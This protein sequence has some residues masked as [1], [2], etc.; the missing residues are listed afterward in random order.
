MPKRINRWCCVCGTKCSTNYSKR[1]SIEG[2]VCNDIGCI[3]LD[4]DL[5]IAKGCIEWWHDNAKR[6]DVAAAILDSELLS[7]ESQC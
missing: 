2:Y 3:N 1:N 5:N 4:V 7:K 6:F